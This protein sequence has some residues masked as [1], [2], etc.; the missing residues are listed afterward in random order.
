MYKIIIYFFIL[1]LTFFLITMKEIILVKNSEIIKVIQTKVTT[2]FKYVNAYAI[3]KMN[4]HNL[5][6]DNIK[7]LTAFLKP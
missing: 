2:F 4:T 6:K 5:N 1:T 3:G 7:G